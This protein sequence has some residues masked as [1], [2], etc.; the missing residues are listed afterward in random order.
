MRIKRKPKAQSIRN[1]PSKMP[2]APSNR[3]MS[4]KSEPNLTNELL[5]KRW[6]YYSRVGDKKAM[7]DEKITENIYEFYKKKTGEELPKPIITMEQARFESAEQLEMLAHGHGEDLEGFGAKSKRTFHWLYVTGQEKMAYKMAKNH[8][9][10]I[11]NGKVDTDEDDFSEIIKPDKKEFSREDYNDNDGQSKLEAKEFLESR[12]F[13]VKMD[14]EDAYTYDLQVIRT[15]GWEKVEVER[16][17]IWKKQNW[18]VHFMTVD[19]PYRKKNNESD[20]YILF[21]HSYTAMCIADM[22]DIKESPHSVK[23]TSYTNNEEFFN[24]PLRKFTFYKKRAG[25][26]KR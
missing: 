4:D 3:R 10:R 9:L 21:N 15:E 23:D 1:Q 22:T 13:E 16:K 18:P 12:G 5:K 7:N 17:V 24:V 8:R 26:W 14:E 2:V 20:I 19:V 6:E 11:R 25:K